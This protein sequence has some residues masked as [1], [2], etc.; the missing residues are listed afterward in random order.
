MMSLARENTNREAAT[1]GA[2]MHCTATTI[3]VSLFVVPREHLFGAAAAMKTPVCTRK[4][5]H[6]SD[7]ANC[8]E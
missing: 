5:L 6:V 2:T 1:A 8:G 4:G 7:V 3:C